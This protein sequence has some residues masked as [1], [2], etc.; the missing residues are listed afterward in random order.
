LQKQQLPRFKSLLAGLPDFYWSNKPKWETKL[1]KWPQKC[2]RAKLYT[3]MAL[4]YQMAIKCAKMFHPKTFLN[5]PKLA[6]LV[7]KNTIWQ[8]CLLVTICRFY[9]TVQ[10]KKEQRAECQAANGKA[11]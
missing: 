8:P 5:I 11:F 7:R 9:Y 3:K 4:K 2:Q 10:V 1:P 6:F